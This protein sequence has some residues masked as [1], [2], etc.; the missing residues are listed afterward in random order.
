MLS[1]RLPAFLNCFFVEL[2]QYLFAYYPWF[3]GQMQ[4]V[5][6]ASFTVQ[7]EHQPSDDRSYNTLLV[8]TSLFLI[9]LIVTIHILIAYR[10]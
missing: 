8:R 6:E 2:G 5:E 9:T 1:A 7:N 4:N 10:Q 3:V